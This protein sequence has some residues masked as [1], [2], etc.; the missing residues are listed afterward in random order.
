[1]ALGV[2]EE[3]GWDRLVWHD[4]PQLFGTGFKLQ[5]WMINIAV[6]LLSPPGNSLYSRWGHLAVS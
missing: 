4:H 2:L 3:L 6:G 1:M 5:Q